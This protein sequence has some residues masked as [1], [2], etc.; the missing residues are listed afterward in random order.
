[1]ITAYI[2]LGFFSALLIL[3]LFVIAAFLFRDPICEIPAVP[4][5]VLSPASGT[6]LSV[7]QAEDPW[8]SRS[9]IKVRI[10]ISAWDAHSLRSPIEGKVMNQWSSSE[11][12]SEFRRR[13]AY[14]IKTDEGDDILM[15]L[16]MSAGTKFTRMTIYSGERSGQGQ[17]CGFLYFAGVIDVYLPANTRVSIKAGERVTSGTTILGYF[18]H[19][20]GASVITAK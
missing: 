20:Q 16:G 14:W 17:R 15:A 8:L 6:V 3:L 2:F 11:A 1:M 5:A 4:L 10:K 9:A 19:A 12:D 18:V 7:A 13:V